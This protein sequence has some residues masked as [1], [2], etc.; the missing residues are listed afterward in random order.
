[1]D[2][3]SIIGQQ[4]VIDSLKNS[5]E[6]EKVG[7]A[8]IFAGPTGI[9]KKTVARIFA[10]MLLCSNSGV[11]GSCGECL[12]CRLAENNS[13]PDFHEVNPEGASIGVD[14]IRDVLSNIVVRPMY[15]KKK[16]YLI[17]DAERMTVQ[18]QNSLLKTLEEPPSY[19]VIILTTSNYGALLE[20]IR[21]RTIKL[22]F[23]KNSPLEIKALLEGRFGNTIKAVDFVTSY[24]DG[25]IGTAL[26]LAG[27]E[28][29]IAL[30]E[31]TLELLQKLRRSKLST[32]FDQYP[33]FEE[34]KE[35]VDVILDIALLFFRDLLAYKNTGDENILINSD[36]KD[37]ILNN[38]SVYSTDRLIRSVETIEN[39]RKIIKQNA[40]Y[41]L[42]IEVM[43]MKLQEEDVEW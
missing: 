23:K 17:I 12:S 43:L 27:S 21:S 38:A 36:K 33:F 9:G 15:G 35:D 19:G 16:V 28:E 4:E 5:I 37:I 32:V 1:M 29:F 34:N 40:N 30:R 2:F 11:A 18:A 7:H 22:S 8:Y 10:S 24:A 41:Q 13:N 31:K 6:S 25:I 14:E 3:S 42:S 20:T 39:T 26:K